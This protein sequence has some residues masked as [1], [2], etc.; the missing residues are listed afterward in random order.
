MIVILLLTNLLDKKYKNF[1][2]TFRVIFKF[3]TPIHIIFLF[4]VTSTKK[5]RNNKTP[6]SYTEGLINL[7]SNKEDLN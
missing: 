2:V 3:Y 5:I 1:T 4:T 7:V 6:F